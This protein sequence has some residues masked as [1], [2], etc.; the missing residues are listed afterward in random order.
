MSELDRGRLR[1]S[2]VTPVFQSEASVA[3]TLRSVAEQTALRDGR[4]EVQHIV[5][6]GASRDATLAEIERARTPILEV[7]SEPDRGMY[8][9]LAKGLR[10]ATGDVVCYLNA[11]DLLLPAAFETVMGVV[12]DT[13]T[14]WFTGTNLLLGP[15]GVVTRIDSPWRYRRD[16]LRAGVYGRVLPFVQ[17]ESTFW[18]R[19][20][21]EGLD[22]DALAGYRLAGD[23]FLW[24]SFAEVADLDVVH[25]AFAGF[26]L[27]AGQLS[28]DKERYFEEMER[29]SGRIG[30]ALRL[31]ALLEKRRGWWGSAARKERTN[32]RAI[33]FDHA[34]QRWTRG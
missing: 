26:T 17:Q 34:L 5:V 13:D 25:T 2:V 16:F 19:E 12:R 28:Q 24:K 20:L 15:G 23:H 6:D 18:R 4:V 30:L 3:R 8:D 22:L 9:A 7:V 10:R 21:L 11:G 1:I 33:R 29:I 32:P 31:A 27:E 14:R